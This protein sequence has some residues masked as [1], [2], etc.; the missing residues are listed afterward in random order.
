MTYSYACEDFPGMAP[1]P[2]RFF[3][4]S[5]DELWAHIELHATKA[6]DEDP[7]AWADED[8]RQIGELIQSE[9]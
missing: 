5:Q 3:A 1:C 2:G 7:A 9:G 6:H 4:A 8:K